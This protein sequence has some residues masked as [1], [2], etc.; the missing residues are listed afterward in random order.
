MRTL[1]HL[2]VHRHTCVVITNG[3]VGLHQDNAGYRRRLDD[4]ASIFSSTRGKPALGRHFT[5]LIDTSI[6]LSSLPRSA[7]DADIAYGDQR[8]NAV[9]GK[10]GIIEVL[11]DRQGTR[12]GAWSAF[13]ISDGIHL[14]SQG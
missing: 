14:R 6:F 11:K 3:A 10:V 2:A 12:E 1:H 7:D 4:Q 13:Q 9:F 5:F 8:S